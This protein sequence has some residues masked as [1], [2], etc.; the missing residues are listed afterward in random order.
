[1]AESGLPILRISAVR[2][3][4]VAQDD[5]RFLGEDSQQYSDYLL[6]ENDLLFTRYN[7]NP[8]F[9]G[10][11]GLVSAPDRDLVYPDKVIRGRCVLGNPMPQYIELAVNQGISRDYIA[12][13]GKTAAGQVGISGSDLKAT[14]VPLAPLQ[15]QAELARI[16]RSALDSARRAATNH[17]A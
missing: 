1:D 10:V 7:G 14:P 16:V 2:P 6:A 13:K 11:C 5:V 12:S 15:E 8:E 9:V 4:S 3:G 17:Q